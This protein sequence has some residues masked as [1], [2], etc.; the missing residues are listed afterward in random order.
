MRPRLVVY[1]GGCAYQAELLTCSMSVDFVSNFEG[2][3]I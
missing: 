2:R 1:S 3:K